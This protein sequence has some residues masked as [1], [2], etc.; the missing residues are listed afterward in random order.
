MVEMGSIR[1]T[2]E[3]VQ[4]LGRM[5]T[6]D[7]ADMDEARADRWEQLIQQLE[8]EGGITNAEAGVLAMSLPSDD[9]DSYGVAWTTLHLIESAPDWPLTE[10]IDK[11]SGPWQG[12]VRRRVENASAH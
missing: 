11:I 10:V 7:E 12:R 6:D 5:P 2:V 8:Q 3:E 1:E 9:S 4:R